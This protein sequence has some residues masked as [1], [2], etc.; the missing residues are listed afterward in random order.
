M[1]VEGCIERAWRHAF[2][3]IVNATIFLPCAAARLWWAYSMSGSVDRGLYGFPEALH[4]SIGM[5]PA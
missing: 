3:L 2:T 4:L 5:A 1:R